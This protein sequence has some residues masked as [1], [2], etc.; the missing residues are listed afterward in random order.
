[1]ATYREIQSQIEHL[2][3]EAERIRREEKAGVVTQIKTL[4]HEHGISVADLEG[5][6]AKRLSTAGTRVA[7]KYRNK[8]TGDTWTG[9]GK[10]PRWL[11]QQL[12]QGHKI[13]EFLI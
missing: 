6:G 9:R 5:R 11:A 4:M 8:T 2:Q 3:A 1:M 10:Q 7:P 13:E 12:S